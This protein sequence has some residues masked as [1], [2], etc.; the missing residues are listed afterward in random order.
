M[1][2]S[3]WLPIIISPAVMAIGGLLIIAIPE[4]LEIRSYL[5]NSHSQSPWNSPSLSKRAR[6]HVQTFDLSTPWSR[7]R[8]SIHATFRLLRTR[9]V[10]LLIP[11]ASLTIPVATVT[12]SII[13]RYMP[14]R[15]GWTLMRTGLV[16]GIRT[17]FNILVLLI[18]LPA[19]QYILTKYN[20]VHSDLALARGSMVLLVLGQAVFA[21]APNIAVA[22]TGLT[23]FT[24]GTSAPSLC[25]ALLARLVDS[26]SIGRM[27]SIIAL[28]ELVGYLACSI[29]LGAL[30]QVGMKLGLDTQGS[31]RVD[32]NG[33]WLA[34][35]FFCAAVMY[36]WCGGMLWVIDAKGCGRDTDG[37]DSIRSRRSGISVKSA[38][39]LRV[40]A[41]GRITR[42]SPSLDSVSVRV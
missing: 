20:N 25:R 1:D 22:L 6:R 33:G 17:G 11:T 13:L 26:D 23:I 28:C 21:A 24:L 38:Q 16:L 34:L 35:V 39:E 36:F 3:V 40:L 32:G 27:F 4:T 30:Y 12:M 31:P 2:H 14:V 37:S 5:E 19:M 42:K 9:D 7:F 41:D 18:F 29:G 8:D 10:K 15:F